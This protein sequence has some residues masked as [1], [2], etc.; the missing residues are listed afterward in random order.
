MGGSEYPAR[1]RLGRAFFA[2]PTLEVAPDL[3]GCYLVLRGRRRLVVR[4]VEVEAYLGVGLDPA[5]HAQS[6]RTAR[7]GQM[8]E[9]PGTLYVYVSYGMHHCLNVVCERR[10]MA[11]AVLLRAAEPIEGE[12]SMRR[13]R[14]RG[15][16]ELSNG[17]GKLA[18]AL[19]LDLRHDG[20]DLVR[21][22]LGVWPGPPPAR[23]AVSTRVGIT[24]AV[25]LPHRF[26]DPESGFVSR[27]RT[28]A[29]GTL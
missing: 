10:G 9:T 29:L 15:G 11:G 18:Q 22:V 4:L 25:G 1:Q 14:G 26:Y 21:G 17:P 3:V 20:A 5:S 19:G 23:I 28:S 24:K 6:G 12:G 13:R 8:F 27:A 2:R 16:L 7:N